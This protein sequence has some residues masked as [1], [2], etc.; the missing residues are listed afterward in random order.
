MSDLLLVL[1]VVLIIVVI[2]RGPKTIPEI[3]R[4]FGRG[5]REARIEASRLR[6]TDE[7]PK[8]GAAPGG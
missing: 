8:D 4:M 6:S 2:M 3:G 5:V 7:Q 1:I